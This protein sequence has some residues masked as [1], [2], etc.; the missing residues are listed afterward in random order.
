MNDVF[1]EEYQATIGLDFQ[2]KNVQIDNQDNLI[3]FLE[4]KLKKVI[5]CIILI[6]DLFHL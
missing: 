2:S 5:S 6:N 4:R 3:F 1:I